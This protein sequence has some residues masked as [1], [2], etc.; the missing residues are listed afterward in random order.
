[1]ASGRLAAQIKNGQFSYTAAD[2]VV[3]GNK[4][5]LHSW[6]GVVENVNFGVSW[7]SWLQA[8]LN[9]YGYSTE[10]GLTDGRD[11]VNPVV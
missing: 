9:V 10:Q 5:F 3:V 6:M 1:M 4:R 11:K 7:G 2:F 8:F